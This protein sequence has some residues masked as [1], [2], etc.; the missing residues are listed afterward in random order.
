VTIKIFYP[1]CSLEASFCERG[2]KDR[3]LR[4]LSEKVGLW[5]GLNSNIPLLFMIVTSKK[6][7]LSLSPPISNI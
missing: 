2:S 3:K 7:S 6:L 1:S 4:Y 5:N